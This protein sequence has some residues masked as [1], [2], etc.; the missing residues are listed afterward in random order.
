MQN[1]MENKNEKLFCRFRSTSALLDKFHELENEEIYFSTVKDLNDPL[2][3]YMDLSFDGDE[4]LWTNFFQNYL[5]CLFVFRTILMLTGDSKELTSDDIHTYFDPERKTFLSVEGHSYKVA[6]DEIFA[7]SVIQKIIN[8]FSNR[9]EAISEDE[10]LLFLQYLHLYFLD[11]FAKIDLEKGLIKQSPGNCLQ[12]SETQLEKFGSIID[13]ISEDESNY[14]HLKALYKLTNTI[15][16][17]YKYLRQL[18]NTG[19]SGIVMKNSQ[20]LLDYPKYY[21]KKLSEIMYPK[22]YITC[23]SENYKDL[24][25]WGYYADSGKGVCLIYKPKVVN[26]NFYIPLKIPHTRTQDFTDMQLKPVSYEKQKPLTPF[27]RSLG[28]LNFPMLEKHWYSLNGKKSKLVEDLFNDKG[29][30]KWRHH[31][32]EHMENSTNIKHICW[33]HEQ[34]YRIAL[35]PVLD[36]TCDTIEKR[37]IKYNFQNLYGLIFGVNTNESDKLRIIKIIQEKCVKYKR[38]DFMLFQAVY[39]N[40]KGEIDIMPLNVLK[41]VIDFDEQKIL[42]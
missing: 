42:K 22:P 2:E 29:I 18:E 20:L 35:I 41:Y 12:Q 5:F 25:M 34:E 39:N 40:A 13:G 36:D 10:L 33:R 19:N 3:E 21:I 9:E 7:N 31:Y 38:N 17:S 15:T 30:D 11:V 6:C 1:N 37:K 28:R 27:F 23:F 16:D 14:L 26:G 24:S 8:Y 32:W 4:I